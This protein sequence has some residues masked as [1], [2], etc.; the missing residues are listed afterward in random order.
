MPTFN[1]GS[2]KKLASILATIISFTI[3]IGFILSIL[4]NY[5]PDIKLSNENAIIFYGSDGNESTFISSFGIKYSSSSSNPIKIS[6]KIK[7]FLENTSLKTLFDVDHKDENFSFNLDD[8]LIFQEKGPQTD[9]VLLNAT[10]TNFWI[11]K[12]NITKNDELE[13][14]NFICEVSIQDEVTRLSKQIEQIIP[15]KWKLQREYYDLNYDFLDISRG[16][17]LTNLIIKFT[18]EPKEDLSNFILSRNMSPLIYD[19]FDSLGYIDSGKDLKKGIDITL[20]INVSFSNFIIKNQNWVYLVSNFENSYGKNIIDQNKKIYCALK[21]LPID[22]I[23]C[24]LIDSDDNDDFNEFYNPR[25]GYSI[26]LVKINSSVYLID[27][28]YD[29]DFEYSHDTIKGIT[30]YNAKSQPGFEL[31]IIF[32]AIT[33]TFLWML[34]RKKSH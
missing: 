12:T 10:L 3:I 17:Y 31:I 8:N 23:T 33:L 34:K 21:E 19:D 14:G 5:P 29:G 7:E 2:K 27:F 28:N 1:Q 26:P 25:F 32:V 30:K 16:S 4:Q 9:F 13:L 24:F 6:F 15:V 22:N 11:D 20:Q 18:I